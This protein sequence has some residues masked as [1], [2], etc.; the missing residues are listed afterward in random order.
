VSNK[1]YNLIEAFIMLCYICKQITSTI[2]NKEVRMKYVYKHLIMIGLLLWI[3]ING[4]AASPALGTKA[5]LGK[6]AGGVD[7][8]LLVQGPAAQAT[9]LQIICVFEYTEGDITTSPPAL[10]KELNGLLHVDEALHGLITELRRSNKFG[11]KLLETLLITPPANTILAEKLLIVGLGN[12]NNFKPEIMKLVGIT[13]MREALRLGVSSYSHA[14]DLKD[15]GI[16]SPVGVVGGYIVSGAAEAY[17]TQMFLY[18]QQASPPLTVK[19]LTLLAGP[20]FFE[21]TKAGIEA[22][23]GQK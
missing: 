4:I 9:P 20:A 23:R 1:N 22:V 5:D 19:K 11:G 13:G 18:K 17:Q 2:F 14:S 12:R 16:D 8:E 3:P 21:D 15:S 6:V 7:I 10:P